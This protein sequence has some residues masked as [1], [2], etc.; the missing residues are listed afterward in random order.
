MQR[1]KRRVSAGL[2]RTGAGPLAARGT[3]EQ[4]LR[5]ASEAGIFLP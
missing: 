2:R 4:F 3:G 5:Y 1:G